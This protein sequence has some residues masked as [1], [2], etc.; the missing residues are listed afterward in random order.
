MTNINKIIIIG[1]IVISLGWANLNIF[2]FGHYH[3]TEDGLPIFHAHPY[4]KENH[5]NRP[6][7]N[8]SHT[9]SE[10]LQLA[11]IVELLSFLILFLQVF[12]FALNRNKRT[13]LFFHFLTPHDF[14]YNNILK[15]G[16]PLYFQSL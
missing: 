16:P 1:L 7:P 6:F 12:S 4:Q 10:L 14:Y 13:P 2:Y 3:I 9:K 5:E 15:R 8:H 11:I